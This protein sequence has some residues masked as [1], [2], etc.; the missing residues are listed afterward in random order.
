MTKITSKPFGKTKDGTPVTLYTFRNKSGCEVSVCSY[1]GTIVSIKVP[2][3]DGKIDDIVLGYDNI[4][5]YESRSYFYGAAIGRCGNRIGLGKFTLNGR[6]YQL[7]CNDGRNHLHGGIFGFD[8]KVW[9]CE[10]KS[11]GTDDVLELRY[12]S[13]DGE[14]NYPGTLKVKMTYSWSDDNELTLHYEAESDKDTICN[15]TNHSYFNLA[16]HK[17][18]NIHPILVKIYAAR[19]TEADNESIP[20]GKILDVAGTPMDF[21]DFHAIG[22]RIDDDYYQLN[23]AGGY[24][25]NWVLDKGHKMGIAAEAWDKNSGR[26]MTCSTTLPD[27]QFYCGNFIKGDQKG[28]DGFVYEKRAGFCFETQFAPDAIN[29]PQFESPVLKAGEKYDETTVY[30]FDIK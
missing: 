17:S 12:T 26:H 8:S 10:V 21:R 1:G 25:H 24:D 30:K 29:K 3:R 14:E 5:S 6:E 9:D 16:G 2:D 28:K 13:P 27:M 4:E 22:E 19:F 7:N 18:G 20:T 11:N 15:L 23:Y